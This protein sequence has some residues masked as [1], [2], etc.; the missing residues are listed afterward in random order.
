MPAWQRCCPHPGPC[1]EP[2]DGAFFCTL[3][4]YT[5]LATRACLLLTATRLNMSAA[6]VAGPAVRAALGRR[7][8]RHSSNMAASQWA[9]WPAGVGQRAE[10]GS[11]A[12]QA[13]NRLQ[14]LLAD[15]R[16]EDTEVEDANNVP[17]GK[18]PGSGGS[19]GEGCQRQHTCR[20]LHPLPP[21]FPLRGMDVSLSWPDYDVQHH[22]LCC[23]CSYRCMHA[24]LGAPA[25]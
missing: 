6:V 9:S 18:W 21:C 23:C 15:L 4:R 1:I 2:I 24:I 22:A 8:I 7:L 20:R 11:V 3:L 17:V 10:R 16:A 19:G 25:C 5:F 14:D 13:R 12:V